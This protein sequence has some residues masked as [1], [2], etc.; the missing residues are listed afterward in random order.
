[1]SSMFCCS[2]FISICQI[3]LGSIDTQCDAKS[4]NSLSSKKIKKEKKHAYLY[5]G[6]RIEYYNNP[7]FGSLSLVPSLH[8]LWYI[9]YR[10]VVFETEAQRLF[11][12]ERS[13]LYVSYLVQSEGP[14]SGL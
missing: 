11:S 14:T 1:M 8:M 6:S 7:I 3:S 10:K 5:P 2:F 4:G 12:V 13:E 9:C